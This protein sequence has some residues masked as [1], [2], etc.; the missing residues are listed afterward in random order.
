MQQYF[1]FKKFL[2]IRINKKKVRLAKLKINQ[3]KK[4]RK[5]IRMMIINKLN[6]HN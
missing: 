5:V 3:A 1:A 6:L 4:A 2:L